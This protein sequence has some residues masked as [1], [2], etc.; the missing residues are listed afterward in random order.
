[1]I[2]SR[3]PQSTPRFG[4]LV[5]GTLLGTILVLAGLLAAYLTLATPI[6]SNSVPIASDGQ[7]VPIGLGIWSFALIA[8][9]GLLIAGTN[10]LAV[11]VASLR[12]TG[13][14]GGPAARALA[15]MPDAVAVAAGVIPIEGRAIPEVV[16][17]AFGV[18]VVH[19]LGSSKQV[20]HGPAGWEARTSDGW[21]PSD[22]PLD[23]AM[24]DAER[25]RRWLGMADL[26]FIVRVYAALVVDDRAL[27]RSPT[28]AV[29]STQQIPAWIASLPRQR[30]LTAG[31]RDR[32]LSIVANRATAERGTRGA[33]AERGGRG[34]N[35]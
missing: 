8:G 5:G 27:E 30:T 28:C 19:A 21:Q 6:L 9:G 16:I 10:R 23:A 11:T 25:M 12:R 15:S 4:A 33:T 22:D 31:R 18:A 17:G 13:S 35:W 3:P 29:I 14:I 1:M 32:L 24:R 2:R 34:A 20:R 26:D 7:G